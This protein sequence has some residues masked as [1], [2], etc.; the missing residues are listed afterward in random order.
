MSADTT[1]MLG[2]LTRSRWSW[3]VLTA[4][5]VAGLVVAGIG[6]SGPSTTEEQVRS[7]GESIQ[8]PIC[9][10][11]SVADSNSSAAN[12]IRTEIARRLEEGQTGDQIRDYISGR[13]GDDVLLTPPQT[14]VAGLIWFLPVAALVVAAGG[15]VAAFRY[16]RASDETTVSEEDADLVSAALSDTDR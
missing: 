1:T 12:A 3:L 16:W 14:G 5:L 4:L 10:G 2:H 6:E 8:C 13:Y 15:L 7:I 9:D 11:Q